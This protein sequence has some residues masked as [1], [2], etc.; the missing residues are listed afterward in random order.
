MKYFDS[1]LR[2]PALRDPRGYILPASQPDFPTATKF[3]NALLKTGVTVH[4][5]TADFE[6][7]GRRYPK[8]SFVVKAAQ[9]FRPH[10]LDMFEPQDHP[11]DFPYPGGPPIPPYDHAGYTLAMTM[12]VA[13]D[14]VLDAFDGP[15]E[16]LSGLAAPLAGLV[17]PVSP[18]GYLI[19]RRVNDA[20]IVVNRLLKGGAEVHAVAEAVEA[21]GTRFGPGTF[22]VGPGTRAH[23][24]IDQA[25]R[26]LGVSA[27]GLPARPTAPMRRI[28]APRIGLWDRYGGS[29]P[30]GWIRWLLE[31]TE[32]SFEVVYPQSLDAG[33]L[34]AAFDVLI[35]PDGAIPE[36]EGA[37]TEFFVDTQPA[38][39]AVPA[40]YRNRLG[41]VSIATTVPQL[42]AFLEEGGTIL[43]IGRSTA[44][45]RHLGLPI[46]SALAERQADG[47]LKPLPRERFYIPGSVMRAAVDP[48]RDIAWGM[49]PE[50]DLFFDESPAFRL[51]PDAAAKGVHPVAWFPAARTLRS[52][53]AWGQHLLEG[54]VAIADAK[55]GQ[56]RLVVFGPEVTMR[57]QTHATFKFLFNGIYAAA[58]R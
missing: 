47:T 51:P 5:A 11:N 24:V 27:V 48:G 43:T 55:V 9:A 50:V 35:F 42:R 13:Y 26:E 12:G 54:A 33:K 1:I 32:F 49:A 39:D 25:A 34:R 44:L 17:P 31:R 45:A 56:G 16:K 57:A 7:A 3:V 4:R 38:A 18:G 20:V 30:S 19:D 8:G 2:D 10:V 28:Q 52:G 23:A 36:R 58:Q 29:M 53:W 15:F 21:S 14:R 41:R 6:V 22:Y 40:E 46:E 37:A